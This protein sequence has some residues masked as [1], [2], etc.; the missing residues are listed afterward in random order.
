MFGQAFL[1]DGKHFHGDRVGLVTK[2]AALLPESV[3]RRRRKCPE[4]TSA[5]GGIADMVGLAVCSARR[6]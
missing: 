1:N 2:S 4:F 5:F 6:E 3:D